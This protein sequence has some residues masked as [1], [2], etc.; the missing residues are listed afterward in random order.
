ML[1]SS[2]RICYVT[3]KQFS[4]RISYH[5]W[6][7]PWHYCMAPILHEAPK[8]CSLHSAALSIGAS[9][10]NLWL[11]VERFALQNYNLASFPFCRW[12]SCCPPPCRGSW[13]QTSLNSIPESSKAS[14]YIQE[15]MAICKLKRQSQDSELSLK[16]WVVVLFSQ[17]SIFW[18]QFCSILLIIWRTMEV[19]TVEDCAIVFSDVYTYLF[20]IGWY[21]RGEWKVV[22]HPK[23]RLK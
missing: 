20:N 15:F 8:Y 11:C 23:T 7:L 12:G 5:L 21:Q 17:F 6:W 19:D 1:S 3:I 16:S 14:F 2:L 4:Y 10:S 18:V 9:G 22:N 13:N